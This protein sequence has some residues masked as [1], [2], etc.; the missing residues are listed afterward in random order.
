SAAVI[1][2]QG[3]PV[4]MPALYRVRVL[5]QRS[6]VEMAESVRV[7]GKMSGQHVARHAHV[8]AMAGLNE[9][10]KIGRG[11]EAA[12]RREQARRLIAPGAV[13][14]MLADGQEFDIGKNHVADITR[15]APAHIPRT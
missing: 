2:D 3:S 12:G 14:R 11:T 6:P 1:V 8:V 7:I 4:E 10:A 13:E 9:R 5:V 15:E